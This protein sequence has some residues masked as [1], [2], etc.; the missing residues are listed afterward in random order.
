MTSRTLFEAVVFLEYVVPVLR[1]FRADF[2]AYVVALDIVPGLRSI[3]SVVA[4][5]VVLFVVPGVYGAFLVA[6]FLGCEV[7]LVGVWTAGYAL[8][9]SLY[10]ELVIFSMRATV[11]A[12]VL[13]FYV[14][15]ESSVVA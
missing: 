7:V 3:A 13:P 12:A 14:K 4:K 15:L 8:V 11:V 6:N 10:V 2:V 5:N 9:R 1:T